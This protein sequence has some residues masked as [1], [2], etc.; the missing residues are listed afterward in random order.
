[1]A[2]YMSRWDHRQPKR[3]RMEKRPQR[4]AG[5]RTLIKIKRLPV[6]PQRRLL[7]QGDIDTAKTRIERD[8]DHMSVTSVDLF[9]SLRWLWG[10]TKR[11]LILTRHPNI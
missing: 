5:L 11:R 1:M 4:Y 9:G 7:K 10:V 3:Y 2:K 8:R 6:R